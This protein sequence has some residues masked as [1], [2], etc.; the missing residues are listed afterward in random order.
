[1]LSAGST[2]PLPPLV[3]SPL[4]HRGYKSGNYIFRNL[5]DAAQYLKGRSLIISPLTAVGKRVGSADR[6]FGSGLQNTRLCAG[7]K[8]SHCWW[9]LARSDSESQKHAWEPGHYPDLHASSLSSG[10]RSI[11]SL[12]NLFLLET[13]RVIPVFFPNIS[14]HEN[15]PSITVCLIQWLNETIQEHWQKNKISLSVEDS[16][17]REW[18]TRLAAVKSSVFSIP[19]FLRYVPS[20]SHF[21]CH[22]TRTLRAGTVSFLYKLNSYVINSK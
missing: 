22:F 15:I 6:N 2:A 9:F 17:R 14:G 10:F 1:M 20:L 13:I 19:S 11:I 4:I 7:G 3:G 18:M 8:W 21:T 12:S 16:W 5:L